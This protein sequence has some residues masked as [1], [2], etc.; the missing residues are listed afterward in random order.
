MST[1]VDKEAKPA[2]DMELLSK[3]TLEETTF[4]DLVS[5][6]PEKCFL[7]RSN[8]SFVIGCISTIM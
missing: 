6:K 3:K 4:A 2:V 8:I 1:T 7:F 5:T